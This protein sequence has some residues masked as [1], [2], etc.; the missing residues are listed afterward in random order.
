VFLDNL[1]EPSTQLSS[2]KMCNAKVV[3]V[4][5]FLDAASRLGLEHSEL[6]CLKFKLNRK[7]GVSNL[8]LVYHNYTLQP[9]AFIYW[10]HNS[11]VFIHCL[12][13]H[14]L[15]FYSCSSSTEHSI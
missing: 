3:R 6:I 12:L 2:S 11:K 10:G 1:G 5:R 8:V 7:F 13:L 4:L 15:L 9:G 14:I